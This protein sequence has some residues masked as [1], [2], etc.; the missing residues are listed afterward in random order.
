M[1]D[2]ENPRSWQLFSK[3]GTKILEKLF[4]RGYAGMKPSVLIH[5]FFAS[6]TFFTSNS[7]LLKF[8]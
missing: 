6:N 7:V 5:V 4:Y 2:I 3:L 8:S 1:G